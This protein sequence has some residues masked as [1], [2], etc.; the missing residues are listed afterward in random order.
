M[1]PAPHKLGSLLGALTWPNRITLLR[2]VLVIPFVMA[3]LQMREHGNPARYVAV[4]LFVFMA[5]SD[6]ADGIL[7]R[8]LNQRS[9][10]GMILDP[11]ADK[12]LIICSTILLAIPSVTP[13]VMRLPSWVVVAVVAKDVWVM[14]G[15]EVIFLVTGKLHMGPTPSGKL[16]T[17]V[18][19]L[20]VG[21]AL[22]AP[23]MNAIHD[24]LGPMIVL[25]ASGAVTALCGLAIMSYTR[26]GLGH[27]A[28]VQLE[29]TT[30]DA[31]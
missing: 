29:Q 21:F 19:A 4:G 22:I 5:L 24:G 1:T 27:L 25:I 12:V 31:D 9:A 8:V 17:V 14:M 15:C 28:D 20:M 3:L 26:M 7:A 11:L 13:E 16:S 30:E 2:F 6:A 18:Q 23:E 10:L